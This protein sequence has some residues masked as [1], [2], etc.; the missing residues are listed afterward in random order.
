M[1]SVIR[2]V[3]LLGLFVVAQ[4]GA[5]LLALFLFNIPN[6]FAEGIFDVNVLGTSAWA[7]GFSL[8]LTGIF[9]FLAML[10]LGWLD[11]KGFTPN[12]NN[13]AVYGYVA[14]LMS[15]AIFLINIFSECLSLEDM[16]QDVFE[17]LMY[18]PLGVAS[19]VLVGPFTEE[20][21]FRMG[22]QPRF[23]KLGLS[24]FVAIVLSALIFGVIH[25]NPAQIPVGFLFGLI[26]GWLYWRSGSIWVPFAAHVLNNLIGVTLVWLTGNMEQSLTELCG[27]GWQVTVCS[28]V[29]LALFLWAYY[30]LDRRMQI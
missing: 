14:M 2:I 28:V 25:M 3:S 8:L 7:L 23:M 21:V 12:G 1:K 29:A 15:P 16:N 18:N 24:P 4:L 22:I 13:G 9:V 27:G 17:K 30:G 26:L 11:Y 6:L 5:S 19:I 20:L 10:L